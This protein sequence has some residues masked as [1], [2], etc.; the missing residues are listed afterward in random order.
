MSGLVTGVAARPCRRLEG[1]APVKWLKGIAVALVVIFALFYM[2]SRPEDAANVV[3]GAF[4][5]VV[6]ATEAVGRFFSSLAS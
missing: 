3:Q 5:A 6:S 4:G 2:I 1:K